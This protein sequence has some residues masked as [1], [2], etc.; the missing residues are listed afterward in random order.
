MESGDRGTRI[1]PAGSLLDLLPQSPRTVESLARETGQT[2]ASASQH[3]Q[4]LR[5]ARLVEAEKR[6]LDA[7]GLLEPVDQ[8][9]R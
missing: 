4:V 3:L 2:I 9:R 1:K 8:K 5:Q 6:G 7:R